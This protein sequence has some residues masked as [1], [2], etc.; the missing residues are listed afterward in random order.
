MERIVPALM[1]RYGQRVEILGDGESRQVRAFLQPVRRKTSEEEQYLPTPLGLRRED[2]WLYL[3][4]GEAALSPLTNRVKWNGKTFD[5]QTAQPIYV[6][7]RLSHWWA[8]LAPGD[9]EAP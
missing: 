7:D 1:R 3:G 6:G 4:E 8:L 5:I 2:R 9:K